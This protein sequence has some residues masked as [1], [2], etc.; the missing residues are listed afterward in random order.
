MICE[1]CRRR[2]GSIGENYWTARG[3]VCP[4]CEETLHRASAPVPHTEN[5]R[6]G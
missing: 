4:M 2:F 6:L 3:G 1:R 5:K